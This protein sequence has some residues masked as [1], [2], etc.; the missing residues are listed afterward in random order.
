MIF[1]NLWKVIIRK[2]VE[3]D[4]MVEKVIAKERPDAVL[5]TMGGQTALNTAL[6]LFRDGTLM[7]R[8]ARAVA[9]AVDHQLG[10]GG[11]VLALVGR[12]YASPVVVRL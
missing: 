10:D 3:Q 4:E 1:P 12:E 7:Q 6:A 2:L 5:P 8:A 9:E 11:R